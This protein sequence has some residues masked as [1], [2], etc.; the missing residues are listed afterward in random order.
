MATWPEISTSTLAARSF[1]GSTLLRRRLTRSV[2][3]LSCGPVLGTTVQM[4]AVAPDGLLGR[5]GDANA[6]PGSAATAVVMACSDA[7]SVFF[8]SSATMTSGPLKPAP[9]PSTS[10]SYAFLVLV[11]LA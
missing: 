11:D 4:A 3:A 7:G 1:G 8:G 10:R 2:V 6:T 5:G 9:N